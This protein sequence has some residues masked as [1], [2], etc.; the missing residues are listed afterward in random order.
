V[1]YRLHDWCISRQRYWGPPIPIIYCDNC[2]PQPVPE[3]DLPVV[4]PDV[5]DFRPDD[6]GISPLARHEQWFVVPCPKCGGDARRETDVSD[7]FLDSAW[8]FLRYPSADRDDVPFDAART[9]KWLPV[10]SYIGGNEHA[11]LHLMYSRFITMVLHDMG[12]L[13]FEEPFTRFRAHGHIIRDGAKMSKTKGNIV[14]PDQYFEQWGAD[15]FRMYLM[16]LGPFQEG[17]DFRD[18]GISGVRSFLNRLW[19]AVVDARKDGAPDAAVIRKLH[20]TIAK[21]GDDTARLSYNTAIAAMMEYMNSV[22]KGDRTPHVDEVRP[23]VQLVAPYAPH[24]AE[25]LWEKLGATD[26]VMNGGWPAF[27]VALAREDSIQLAVQVNGKLRGTIMV[28]RDVTQDAAFAA[29]MAEPSVAKFVT[30]TPRKVV[31]VPGRLLNLVV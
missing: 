12:H 11:V 31:F 3:K 23:L 30:T 27:D 17:G 5:A 10:T 28:A 4:L 21:V 15:S 6:T 29:A 18:A 2:G 14:I 25:E 7:T 22:R 13:N 24:I 9:R 19:L 20:Q 26:S 16:F 8:Y 1:N